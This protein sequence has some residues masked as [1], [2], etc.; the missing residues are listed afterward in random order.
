MKAMILAAGRGSRLRPLTDKFPKP[1][2]KIGK[3]TLI[4]HHIEKLASAGFESIVI[5]TA[6]LGK[7]IREHIGNGANY[8]IPIS[9]SDEGEQALETGGGIAYALPLLGEEPFL[10]ISADI[11]CE[12]PF[13]KEFKFNNAQMH[14][15]M[16]ENPAHNLVGDFS[17]SEINLKTHAKQRFT[18][19]GVAY[20]DPRLFTHEKR[21]FPLIDTIHQCIN[22]N[23][24][25]A[26]LF[27]G[28]WFD[29]G[30]ASRLHTA[31]KYALGH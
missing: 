5:N 1:L 13:N 25:S 23:T 31:N 22:N 17:N 6:H 20:I 19:S 21:S 7:Q 24:I 14:L 12:I 2:I 11:Y 28:V 29:V 30:T 27:I 16:V 9:Y 4:E 3:K 8:D 10:V 18:Y 15:F 26:E